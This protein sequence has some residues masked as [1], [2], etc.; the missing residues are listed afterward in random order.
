MYKEVTLVFDIDGTICPIKRKEED[1]ADLIPDNEILDKI[2]Y[3]KNEGAKIVLYTSRN[4]YKGNVGLI[5]ANT[6]PVLLKWLKKW[7]IPY[8]EIVFGKIWPGHKG[9][10][11]DDRSIRPD[12][13]LEHTYEELEEICKKSSVNKED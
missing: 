1:Y 7:D 12:E 8:D 10:Y 6:A 9:F 2:K 5:N 13:F 3:Y 11:I 4:S